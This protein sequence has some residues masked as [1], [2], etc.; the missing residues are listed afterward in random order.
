MRFSPRYTFKKKNIKYEVHASSRGRL[1]YRY[2]D[3]KEYILDFCVTLTFI[4]Q[5][6][7]KM[8]QDESLAIL[9][10]AISC[11]EA[12][13][14]QLATIFCQPNFLSPSTTVV[15]GVKSTGK[16]LTIKSVLE[17]CNITRH[18]TIQSAE[19]VDSRELLEAVVSAVVNMSNKE[20][21]KEEEE[22]VEEEDDNKKK[23]ID[24]RKCES[25]S[26][27]VVQLQL[28]LEGKEKTILVFDGIDRQQEPWLSLL[29]AIARLGEVVS[30]V[31]DFWIL[32]W[33]LT[34]EKF[35]S[36]FSVF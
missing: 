32:L 19:W 25:I 7:F 23:H 13:I 29:P 8:L 15:Y 31:A 33:I 28:L 1:V 17:S 18:A 36:M 30:L 10:D 14:R 21:E 35:K 22:E 2:Y 11:R 26:A 6:I 3:A 4:H 9:I 24:E 34:L 16:S 20:K 12:Q 5:F 27:F